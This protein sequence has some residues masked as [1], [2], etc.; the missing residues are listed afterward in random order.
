[1]RTGQ[2]ASGTYLA[3][4]DAAFAAGGAGLATDGTAGAFKKVML[5]REPQAIR[6]TWAVQA[7]GSA[8]IV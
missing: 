2:A 7:A 6:G 4:R 8:T 5:W 1:M 3:V